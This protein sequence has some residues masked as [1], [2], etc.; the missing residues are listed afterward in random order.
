MKKVLGFIP[1]CLVC[2]SAG[3][4]IVTNTDNGHFYEVVPDAGV[5]WLKAEQ[6]A[7]GL[8][9]DGLQGHLA[10]ITSA[11]EDGFVG[12]AVS[13]AAPS[14]YW[15]GGYQNPV[16]ETDPT[17]G[18]TWVNG[19]GT[20]PGINGATGSDNGYSNWN[21]GE[22]NDYYGSASEQYLGINLGTIGGFNDEGAL[23]LIGGYVVEF[24]P[25]T[26]PG[27]GLAPGYVPDAASTSVM[28]MGS[29]GLL[30]AASRRFRK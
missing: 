7:L 6:L 2:G 24:D 17:K 1:F 9:F 5:T 14:E 25:N 18:W 27:G 22:P 16:T 20:F 10:T 29:L 13:E 3:A 15:L 28:L 23:S 30:G 4:Q 19:E 8:H 11:D 12:T 21:S 26:L